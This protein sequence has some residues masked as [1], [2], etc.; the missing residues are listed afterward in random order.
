[1]DVTVS[2]YRGTLLKHLSL[3]ADECMPVEM[4]GNAANSN[5]E[6]AGR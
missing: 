4:G 2:G 1:M 5:R 3:F 6:P